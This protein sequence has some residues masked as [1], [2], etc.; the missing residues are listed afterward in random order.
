MAKWCDEGENRVLNILFGSTAVDS[1]LYLGLFTNTTE[2]AESA[3]L[4]AISE[5]SG[6][7]YERKTLARGSWTI[8]ADLASYAQQVF[9]ATGNWGNVYG[10]FIATSSDGSGKLLGAIFPGPRSPLSGTG[11]KRRTITNTT[12]STPT[13]AISSGPSRRC[14]WEGWNV[15]RPWNS[16]GPWN[17]ATR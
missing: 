10:Y 9:T 13:G 16:S 2:P 4:A 3:N 1:N 17:T 15:W 6:N 7:G 12:G 14:R 5:P 8:N 11:I